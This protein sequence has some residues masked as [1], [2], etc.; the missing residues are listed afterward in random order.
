M[1]EYTKVVDGEI[2]TLTAEEVAEFLAGSEVQQP[3]YT[4]YKTTIWLRMSDPEAET[5][6]AAK[7][8]QPAKFRGLWDDA[9]SVQ[10]DSQFFDTLKE[11][12]TGV[13]SAERADA[14][15]QPE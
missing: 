12:L 11:F 10:S 8:Q 2:V 1:T 13:L 4:L 5:V 9:L 15:L 3:A 6:M 14:L 7:D